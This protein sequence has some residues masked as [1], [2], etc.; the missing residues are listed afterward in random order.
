M[1]LRV[2]WRSSLRTFYGRHHDLLTVTGYLCHKWPRI[3][4]ICPTHNPIFSSFMTYHRDC[5]KCNA[6]WG[7]F[8]SI[9]CVILCRLLFVFLSFFFLPFAN[10]Q[11]K[12]TNNDLQ[13]TTQKT[14]LNY[15]WIQFVRN[16]K[17]FLHLWWELRLGHV[18][19]TFF[20]STEY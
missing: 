7:S 1:W 3:C 20:L 16:G 2:N 11:V 17:Q 19:R 13:N 6:T 8:C 4:S 18:Y 10:N 9:F 5:N 14:R 15:G 12:G